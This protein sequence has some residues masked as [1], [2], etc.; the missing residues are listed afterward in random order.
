[1]TPARVRAS[2]VDDAD[3]IGRVH[4]RAWQ[5]AY[6]G[7]IDGATEVDDRFGLGVRELRYRRPLPPPRTEW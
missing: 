1:M 5:A 7:L 4:V 6:R 3:D 2:R